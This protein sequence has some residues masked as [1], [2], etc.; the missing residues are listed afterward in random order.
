MRHL[1]RGLLA[2]PLLLGALLLGQPASAQDTIKIGYIDP[3][4]GAFAQQGDASLQHFAY[5][6]DLINAQGGAMGKKLEIVPYDSKLQPAEALIALNR[7]IDQN[8]PF[9]MQCAG[10]NIAAALIDGV[11]KHNARNPD[12]RI[13]YLNCGALASD[14]TNEK[15]DFWHFRFDANTGQRAATLVRALPK[16]VTSVYLLNQD[17]L[18]GQT[19]QKE[20]KEQLALLRPDVK[21]VGE[22]LIP[23][24]K[25]KDFSSYIEKIRDSK[26]QVLITGNWGP[27][28][29]LMLKAAVDSG[30]P[31]EFY[32]YL[33]HVVGAPTATGAAGENRLHT[34]V[35]FHPNVPNEEGNAAGEAF[36]A[37]WRKNHNFDLFQMNNYVMLKMLAAAID[38]AQSTDPLKVAL[39]L[40][41][42]K[43]T[44][45]MGKD[46]MMRK[47]D[48]QLMEPLYV[49]KFTR[50]V[51][52]DSENTGLGWK[53]IGK[54]DAASLV[55]PT[56]CKMKRPA[57]AG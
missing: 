20:T 41:G 36:V 6:I 11:S 27:D 50:D 42:I 56:T 21:V 28:L 52:Y 3:L 44:D 39:A 19:L 17:Y 51:K 37:N 14:L 26:A 12:H 57:G 32:T 48:H 46:Y 31:I 40:E 4:S 22:E 49:A 16:N 10:S 55:Q 33:S 18:F 8:I 30:L 24:G 9:V 34:V 2:A 5:L 47:D 23:L 7:I 15:C 25:V 43:T 53:T 54:S 45:V 29:N 1:I 38:K 13:L 35:E